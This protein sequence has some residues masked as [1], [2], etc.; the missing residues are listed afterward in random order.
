[1][2]WLAAVCRAE[3]EWGD[4][5]RGLAMS[6]ARFALLRLEE[7]PPHVKNWRPQIL[8]LLKLDKDLKVKYPEMATFCS[9][10]KAGASSRVLN[11]YVIT[12]TL[13][14]Y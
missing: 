1:M 2:L 12:C 9:Q 5:I 13:Y 6:A 11:L 14:T 4:G 3:K 7:G 8:I 10:L